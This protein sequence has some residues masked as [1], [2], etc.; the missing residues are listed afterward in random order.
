MRTRDNYFSFDSD[1][2]KP[3]DKLFEDQIDEFDRG[4]DREY[5]K[6]LDDMI[7]KLGDFE[8]EEPLHEADDF[9]YDE[10]IEEELVEKKIVRKRNGRTAFR[11]E[12]A[13][14]EESD[15]EEV[16]QAHPL[17]MERKNRRR[18]SPKAVM[19]NN[20]KPKRGKKRH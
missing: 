18:S 12:R 4:E 6:D 11:E 20:S 7:W 17:G 1:R 14:N 2:I 8:N 3:L 9:G 10:P 15:E 19:R 16:A 5:D 13:S